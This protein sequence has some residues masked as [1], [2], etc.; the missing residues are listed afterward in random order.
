MALKKLN[1]KLTPEEI[2]FIEKQ[3]SDRMKEFEQVSSEK[4][5]NFNT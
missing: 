4:G 5:K 3:S 2:N 1:E